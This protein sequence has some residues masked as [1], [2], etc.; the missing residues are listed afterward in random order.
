MP[1]GDIGSSASKADGVHKY[2]KVNVPDG[3]FCHQPPS[4]LRGVVH[5]PPTP[6]A[7]TER[8][9]HQTRRICSSTTNLLVVQG[10]GRVWAAP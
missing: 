6:S 3:S 7:A 4:D 5:V 9:R 8:H 10:E 1:T 2:Y